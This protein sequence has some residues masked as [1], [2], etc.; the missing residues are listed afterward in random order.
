MTWHSA[1]AGSGR[2]TSSAPF[3]RRGFEGHASYLDRVLRPSSALS[4]MAMPMHIK[5]GRLGHHPTPTW[6]D[7]MSYLHMRV[8]M[9]GEIPTTASLARLDN[10][11]NGPFLFDYEGLESIHGCHPGES[12]I[13]SS[14]SGNAEIDNKPSS[15]YDRSSL[16]EL[17]KYVADRHIPCRHIRTKDCK[18]KTNRKK[19]PA[20][21]EKVEKRKLLAA[22]HQSDA[23]TT[24]RFLDLPLELRENIYQSFLVDF[25]EEREPTQ[26]KRPN[27]D[28][29]Y[30]RLRA[31]SSQ[32]GE[33][34]RVVFKR[35]MGGIDWALY[36]RP[37]GVASMITERY[38]ILSW[39]AMW[40]EQFSRCW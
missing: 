9:I 21:K 12:E 4:E 20:T 13:D 16:Q 34:A 17:R 31:V 23:T 15:L 33:E 40:V 38:R 1:L 25:T 28:T 24:F 22:L 37:D 10:R 30:K 35:D 3:T 27:S 14:D 32:F 8:N 29:L 36:E 26:T 7:R 2:E 6:P 19:S 39:L 18:K 5:A 11:M